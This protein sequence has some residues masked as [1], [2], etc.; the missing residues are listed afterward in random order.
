MSKQFYTYLHCRP[1]GTPFY[2][3]K[4][5]GRRSHVFTTARNQH[6]RNIV[7]KYG[8]ENIQIFVFFCDSEQQSTDDEILQIKSLRAD[9]CD[10]C[11]QTDGGEGS[12]GY[13]HTEEA[14]VKMSAAKI[15]KP[16]WNK[17][18]KMSEAAR[19]N[20]SAARK[21]DI[22]LIAHCANLS[23]ARRGMKASAENNAKQSA[24]MMGHVVSAE[25]RAKLSAAHKGK[26]NAAL[27]L[28][29]IGNKNT[30]GMKHSPETIERMSAIHK[31]RHRKA[32]DGE[33]SAYPT[34]K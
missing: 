10:L 28:R 13:V 16:S 32:R 11:N 26:K 2:V 4:G 1:D 17:G 19:A 9:G 24:A 12:V 18:K 14:R 33:G 7:A 21:G 34:T 29:N 6:H 30:L 15:G 27:S 23:A 25:T 22:K 5:V 8:K 31:E 3:G 20:M